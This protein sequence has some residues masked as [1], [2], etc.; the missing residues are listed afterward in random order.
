MIILFQFL[1]NE[2]FDSSTY[3]DRKIFNQGIKGK[4]RYRCMANKSIM[5]RWMMKYKIVE[6][7]VETYF[8]DKTNFSVNIL[9]I[10]AI[11]NF[12]DSN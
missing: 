5:K 12:L 1:T 10:L 11:L 2:C 3:G 8:I 7:K 4:I 9:E 6:Y